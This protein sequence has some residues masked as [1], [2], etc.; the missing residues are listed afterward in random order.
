V[1]CDSRERRSEVWINGTTYRNPDLMFADII[2]ELCHCS[3][4]ERID[5][6]F[7]TI[8]FTERWNQ[9]SR[10]DEVRFG[11]LAHMLY[12]AWSHVDI[13]V[14]DLRS[15]HWPE[16]IVHD[17]S[18]FAQG[19]TTVIQAQ[20]WSVLQSPEIVIGLAQYQAE[21]NRQN[22]GSPDLFAALEASGV[23]VDDQIKRLAQ[24]FESLPRLKYKPKKDLKVLERSV[25]EV[26]K[27][28]NF[29]IRP[30]LIWEQRWVWSLD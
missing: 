9:I 8:F 14:N 29:P 4:A 20:E 30:H 25:Q 28:F 12:L 6:A 23:G 11:Q 2:H 22:V 27:M 1:V 7:S 19:T 3:L 21:R 15:T 18:N 5:P 24:Y 26:A 16:L 17:H 10:E 13:W